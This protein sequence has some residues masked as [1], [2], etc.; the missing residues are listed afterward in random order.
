MQ[1]LTIKNVVERHEALDGKKVRLTGWIKSCENYS[2]EMTE[3]AAQNGPVIRI[4]YAP[5]F[6]RE[7]AKFNGSEVHIVIDG[8]VHAGC[9]DHETDA[10]M[11]AEVVVCTDRSGQLDKPKLIKVLETKPLTMTRGN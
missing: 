8:I 4:G 10:K 5:H 1:S 9:F 2:C 3:Q 11:P 6:D 7:F